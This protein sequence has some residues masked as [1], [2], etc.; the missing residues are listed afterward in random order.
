MKVA[1]FG[2]SSV[3]DATAMNRCAELICEQ[4]GLSVVVVSAT[5]NTT[6][7]LELIVGIAKEGQLEK[8][9]ELV[10][11]L[12]SRHFSIC[13]EIEGGGGECES[14]KQLSVK[15]SKRLSH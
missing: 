14:G 9:L 10:G 13:E 2:G 12:Q 1:K 8:A 3:K 4:K 5:K 6:N 11:L 15:S 7:E